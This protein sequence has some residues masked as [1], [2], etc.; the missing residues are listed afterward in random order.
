MQTSTQVLVMELALQD[1][2]LSKPLSYYSHQK[3]TKL[4]A[5]KNKVI[6]VD[7]GILL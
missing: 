6:G 3:I 5:L 7:S 2:P 1:F 4:H